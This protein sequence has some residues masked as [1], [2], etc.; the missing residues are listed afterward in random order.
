LKDRLSKG[1]MIPFILFIFI[2]PAY[3][4]VFD[5][6]QPIESIEEGR[7]ILPF[8]SIGFQDLKLAIADLV[9]DEN[10][11]SL[12][13][14][15]KH[16]AQHDFQQK[17]E[18]SVSD[19]FLLRM[20]L[21]KISNWVERRMIEAAYL[22]FDDPV[23]PASTKNG[24]MV[25]RDRTRLMKSPEEFGQREKRIIDKGV[26]V[27]REL[28]A[29]FPDQNFYAFYIQRIQDSKFYPRAGFFKDA[30]IGRSLDY[31]E[32]M[33]PEKLNLEKFVFTKYD[34]ID[35]FYQTDP[36]WNIRGVCQAYDRI[37]PILARNYPE[38]SPKLNCAQYK[39]IPGVKFLGTFAR[40]TLYPVEP[41]TF[42]VTTV[43]LPPYTML[44]DGKEVENDVLEKYFAGDFD[45]GKYTNHFQE[46]YGRNEQ[47]PELYFPGNP[48][49]NL[50]IIGSSYRKPIVFLLASHYSYTYSLD[51]RIH[52]KLRLSDFLKKHPVDD[53]LILGEPNVVLLNGVWRIKP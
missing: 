7:E 47:E 18:T 44:I 32:S 20:G 22:L 4:V 10:G 24:I 33:K 15:V 23:I 34:D 31:F 14:Y 13:E 26:E 16:F 49:R 9:V 25:T 50:L 21:I 3:W 11:T 12:K 42:E 30:D 43:S 8:P 35:Y 29:K 53:I 19:R 37:Y 46:I 2:L 51:L 40:E 5:N 38:I 1:I 28:L 27:Y 48:P 52:K 17:F 6:N 45:R 36:H 39:T 41:E